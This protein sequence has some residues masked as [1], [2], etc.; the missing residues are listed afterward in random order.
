VYAWA[1]WEKELSEFPWFYDEA[2]TCYFLS[3]R[4]EVTPDGGRPVNI[5]KGDLVTFPKGMRCTWKVLRD[6][7]KHYRFG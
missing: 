3:G 1:V 2:E 7:R 6:V 5:G 4:V